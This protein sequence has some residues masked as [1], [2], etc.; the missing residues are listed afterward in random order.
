MK[1]EGQWLQEELTVGAHAS[2][3]HASGVTPA[4]TNKQIIDHLVS[5]HGA[6][7]KLLVRLLICIDE[8]QLCI[9]AENASAPK[10]LTFN[11][12]RE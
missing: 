5:V 2:I 11:L 3:Q 12:D 8:P 7:P 4:S 10:H 6:E 9:V 1:P